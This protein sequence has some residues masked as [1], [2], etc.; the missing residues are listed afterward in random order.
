MKLTDPA[1]ELL[2]NDLLTDGQSHVPDADANALIALVRSAKARRSRLR[3]QWM[4]SAASLALAL[5]VAIF[6]GRTPT[7][8]P[9]AGT[10]GAGDATGDTARNPQPATATPSVARID[11]EALLDLLETTP[12]AVVEWP[13]GRRSLLLVVGEAKPSSY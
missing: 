1:K 4:G 5:A 6:A 7:I 13:D 11:D 10:S 12:S 3:V 9:V 2:L 8:Y